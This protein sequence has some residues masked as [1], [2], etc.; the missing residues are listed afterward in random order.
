[1]TLENEFFLSEAGPDPEA[2]KTLEFDKNPTVLL[3]FAA[4]RFTRNAAR[5]YQDRYGVGAMDWR[6]LV[7]LTKE[8]DI[9]AARASK[10]IGIDKAA[11]SRSLARLQDM[12]LAICDT[13]QGDVRRKIWRLTDK[14]QQLHRDILKEALQRQHHILNGF[15]DTEVLQF[16]GFLQRLLNNVIALDAKEESDR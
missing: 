7:M 4:N 12:D 8:P 5:F 10:V 9:P 16:N 1:M 14:G 6:M 3:V 2:E 15:S 11:V 13:P